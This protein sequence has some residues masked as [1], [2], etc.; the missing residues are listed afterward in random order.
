MMM[1]RPCSNKIHIQ[2][3]IL[4]EKLRVVKMVRKLV[5]DELLPSAMRCCHCRIVVEIVNSLPAYAEE[6]GSIVGDIILLFLVVVVVVVMMMMMM[7]S[8]DGIMVP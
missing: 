3:A 2:R 6:T 7:V 4:H 8:G 1:T 5:V